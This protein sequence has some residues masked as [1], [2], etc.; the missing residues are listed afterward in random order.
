[1]LD[2]AG[3]LKSL[4]GGVNIYFVA[5]WH[6]HRIGLRGKRLTTLIQCS[7]SVPAQWVVCIRIIVVYTFSMTPEIVDR[8]QVYAVDDDAAFLLPG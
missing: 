2:R 3:F 6:P 8:L 1:M 4:G 7:F 5:R